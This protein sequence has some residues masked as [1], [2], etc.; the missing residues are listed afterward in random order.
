MPTWEALPERYQDSLFCARPA[1]SGQQARRRD[2]E[3]PV[4]P[5]QPGTAGF[6]LQD[7][8]LVAQDEDLDPTVALTV[9][10]RHTK[11]GAQHHIEA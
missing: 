4:A 6:A 3:Q 1:L 9:C 11:G 8:H 10:E 7:L 5:P 2:K